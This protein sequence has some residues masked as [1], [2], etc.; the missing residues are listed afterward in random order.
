[1]LRQALR[2]WKYSANL[3]NAL[4]MVYSSLTMPHTTKSILQEIDPVA[5]SKS[6]PG[7][8]VG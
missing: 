8:Q 5:S 2:G 6:T 1:M 3:H 4:H 7:V